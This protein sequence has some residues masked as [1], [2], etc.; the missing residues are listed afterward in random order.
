MQREAGRNLPLATGIDL[1]RTWLSGPDG[2]AAM[3]WKGKTQGVVNLEDGRPL[4]LLDGT[5][6]PLP[7]K[8]TPMGFAD[9]SAL[10]VVGPY[11]TIQL[12]AGGPLI[13]NGQA[14]DPL[15]GHPVSGLHRW[16]WQPRQLVYSRDNEWMDPTGWM[17]SD[18]WSSPVELLMQVGMIHLGAP[19]GWTRQAGSE[20]AVSWLPASVDSY[21]P[22]IGP[23]PGDLPLEEDPVT[24]SFL[25]SALPGAQPVDAGD[26][27]EVILQHELEAEDLPPGLELRILGFT[28]KEGPPWLAP[29]IATQ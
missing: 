10:G 1:E 13:R 11:G 14:L 29:R 6:Q 22:P 3:S 27:L 8:M 28:I 18:P 26:P 15:S 24:T 4:W 7:L 23:A 17:P 5:S 21:R 20:P 25:L 9:S 12:F 2:M 16:S 19:E